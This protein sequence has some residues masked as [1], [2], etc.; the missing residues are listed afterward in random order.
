MKFYHDFMYWLLQPGIDMNSSSESS[1]SLPDISR[2]SIL[3]S[4]GTVGMS[5]P[6]IAATETVQGKPIGPPGGGSCGKE[7]NYCSSDYAV[8][9]GD[10]HQL[11]Q[12]AQLNYYGRNGELEAPN[13]NLAVHEFQLSALSAMRYR[14]SSGADWRR[15]DRKGG[16]IGTTG[17][18]INGSTNVT[19]IQPA[20]SS[21]PL[22][23]GGITSKTLN[24]RESS[25]K[26]VST[27]AKTLLSLNP[28]VGAV[29]SAG[30]VIHAI[31]QLLGGFD[32]KNGQYKKT[33]DNFVL[34]PE[35]AHQIHFNVTVPVTEDEFTLS[36]TNSCGAGGSNNQMTGIENIFIN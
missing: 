5:A 25:I 27:I 32:P 9:S 15:L 22:S 13:P 19:E 31:S 23:V 8:K 21:D 7:V 4:L 16:W 26:N 24:E 30:Q 10:N 35:V 12:T 36:I 2:R 34:Q 6:F 20:G 11:T 14:S 3:T 1:W 28:Y 18:T 33:F 29:I 17:L